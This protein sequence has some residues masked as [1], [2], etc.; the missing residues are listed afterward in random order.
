MHPCAGIWHLLI[1]DVFRRFQVESRDLESLEFVLPVRD[2]TVLKPTFR[3]YAQAPCARSCRRTLRGRPWLTQD[4]VF[5][6][7]CV[8]AE[9]SRRR[10]SVCID[11]RGVGPQEGMERARVQA[12]KD[13][14]GERR[15]GERSP[16]RSGA[17][18]LYTA[19]WWHGRCGGSRQVWCNRRGTVPCH[20][21]H[22]MQRL[23]C[24]TTKAT[25]GMLLLCLVLVQGWW[26]LKGMQRPLHS[27]NSLRIPFLSVPILRHRAPLF[28]MLIFPWSE[29][30]HVCGCRCWANRDGHATL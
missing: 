4:L 27:F 5:S 28:C 25:D 23:C 15:W 13:E 20:R 26:D 16:A 9:A 22:P 29:E 3:L 11:G 24:N 14:F 1:D 6:S 10:S 7:L 19:E 12:D 17:Q 2:K 18:S 8:S 21:D 30:S